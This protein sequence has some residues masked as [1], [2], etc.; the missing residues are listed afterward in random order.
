MP[1][2]PSNSM[3]GPKI[4][5]T[6]ESGLESLSNLD[7]GIEVKEELLPEGLGYHTTAENDG[8]FLHPLSPL[9]K[10][11]SRSRYFQNDQTASPIALEIS[12]M[13]ITNSATLA[14]PE[15]IDFML[16]DDAKD[17]F[18]TVKFVCS[19]NSLCK[20][21]SS[22]NYNKLLVQD[23]DMETDYDEMEDLHRQTLPHKKRIAKRL[24][25]QKKP[26]SSSQHTEQT[27]TCELCNDEFANQWKFFEHLKSHYESNEVSY[28]Y[29]GFFN[30]GSFL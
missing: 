14:T 8:T 29:G 6:S 15:Q 1:I 11:L 24:R 7:G 28:F 4:I 20:R 23:N 9:K 26:R 27:Y 12:D 13:D 25:K 5:G 19:L 30:F 16:A 18:E 2:M 21:I 22:K 17:Q 10:A 3:A